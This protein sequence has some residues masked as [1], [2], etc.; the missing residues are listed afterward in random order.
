[1][2]EGI[3]WRCRVG[4]PRRD[5]PRKFGPRQKLWKRHRRDSVDGTWKRVHAEP[6]A[7]AEAVGEIDW[8]VSVDSTINRAHLTSE[9]TGGGEDPAVAP[10]LATTWTTTAAATWSSKAS[11]TPSSGAPATR[12]N[13]L[14]LVYRGG[15]VLRGIT[16]RLKA[17]G[18]IP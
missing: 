7:D 6:L 1:M 8:A 18:H 3:I 14:A 9:P 4:A 10:P 13:K 17:L 16:L 5:V 15:A 11:T 2:I 12:Y